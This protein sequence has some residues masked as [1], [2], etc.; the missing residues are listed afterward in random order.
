MKRCNRFIVVGPTGADPIKKSTTFS[1][2]FSSSS[3]DA[4]PLS[5]SSIPYPS[6]SFDELP[7]PALSVNTKDVDGQGNFPRSASDAKKSKCRDTVGAINLTSLAT[8]DGVVLVA[9]AV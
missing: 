2:I 4:S 7:A 9:A 3:R 1:P 5:S 8:C 6:P